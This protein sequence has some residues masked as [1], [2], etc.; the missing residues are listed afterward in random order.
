MSLRILHLPTS[1]AGLSWGMSRGER[2]IGLDSDVL[3]TENNWLNYPCD[4]NLGLENSKNRFEKLYKLIKCFLKIRGRYDIYHFNS[5]SSLL[6]FK[7]IGLDLLDLPFYG[8]SSK[9]FI[10]Y[11]GCDARQKYA[12]A[13]KYQTSACQRETCYNGI[14][15]NYDVEIN[16]QK[17]ITKFRKY[18]KH[19]FSVN[20]DLLTF[21]PKN[22]TFLPYTISNWDFIEKHKLKNRNYIHI[23]HAPTNRICKG[24][25]YVLSALNKLKCIYK[26]NVKISIVEHLKHS[27]AL[28]I[29]EDADLIIDQLLIGWYGAFAVEAMKMGKPVMCF[30]R[31]EDLESIPSNMSR[32][33]LEAIINVN[34]DDIFEKL[35]TVVENKN[36][37]LEHSLNGYE[38]VEKYHN[39]VNVANLVNEYYQS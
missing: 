5:G 12:T 38:Y 6:D 16:K 30:I 19:V 14:C 10:T 23:V 4:I 37:L 35:C 11:N 31:E 34:K 2:K 26:N 24:S 32:D 18:A 28:K 22:S 33:C 8:S 3:V 17:R 15:N 39:P 7:R 25:D 20:P 21:L 27:E 36:I 13:S 29:Y 1:V 9:I